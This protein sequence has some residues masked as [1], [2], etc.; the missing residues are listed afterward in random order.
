MPANNKRKMAAQAATGRAKRR[1]AQ[2]AR[3][4]TT[5]EI[6]EQGRNGTDDSQRRRLEDSN[7]G[8]RRGE[9][10]ERAEASGS[11]ETP[12]I[13]FE[14]GASRHQE[15]QIGECSFSDYQGVGRDYGPPL[16]EVRGMDVIHTPITPVIS[17]FD[18]IGVHVTQKVKQKIWEGEYI[19]LAMLTKSSH[20]M[21]A[22]Q[23][24]VGE[25]VFEG[26]KLVV[27]NQTKSGAYWS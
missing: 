23:W 16:V 5:A 19:D 15:A 6:H 3:F 2:P 27:K 12:P 14:P 10:R 7:E 26:G 13:S 17:V 8:Q 25:L 21:E 9:H 1:T 11:R 18:G 24:G 22:S 20:E 4:R